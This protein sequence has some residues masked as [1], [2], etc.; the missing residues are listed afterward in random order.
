MAMAPCPRCGKLNRSNARF[1]GGCG[2]TLTPP[3]TSPQPVPTQQVTQPAPQQPAPQPAPSPRYAPPPTAPQPRPTFS[4]TP[5]QTPPST[6][7]AGGMT[8]AVRSTSYA[9]II[10]ALVAAVCIVGGVLVTL[11]MQNGLIPNI[12][13][14]A[15][16]TPTVLATS[17]VAAT[18]TAISAPTST[19]LSGSSVAST[20]TPVAPISTPTDEPTASATATPASIILP[21][22]T[23]TPLAPGALAP[24]TSL[25]VT[26]QTAT[27]S[28]I[29]VSV[30]YADNTPANNVYVRVSTQK[31]DV[32]GNPAV[33]DS[34]D[35]NRT[36][37]AGLVTFNLKPGTYVV[38]ADLA[39][40]AYGNRFNYAV[41]NGALLVLDISLSRIRVGLKDA[42]GKPLG[43]KYVAVYLQKTDISG[44]PARGDQ[45]N[46]NRTDNTGAVIFNVTAGYYDVEIGDI[47]GQPYG[48]PFNHAARAG[49]THSVIVGLGR[50]RVGVKDADGKA[51]SGKYVTVN[52]QKLDVDGKPMIGDRIDSNRTDNTGTIN[53][54]L[55]PGTYATDIGDLWGAKWGD[56]LN[57]QIQSGAT[58]SVVV[59]LGRITVG[60]KSADGKPITGR[61]VTVYFQK[62]DVSG[63]I[64]KG[65]RIDGN[66]TDNAGLLSWDITAGNYILEIEN[67]TPQQNIVVQP[68][69]ITTS[70]GK[71]ATVH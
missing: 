22:A 44:N 28:G 25:R 20:A 6:R 60:L 26:K 41:T 11:L 7:P 62:K 21:D 18:T 68:S 10:L 30:R 61:Y 46:S 34:V 38:E 42:D 16:Q 5:T 33:G 17:A 29:R 45:V 2:L 56:P 57:K 59:S 4:P 66:R 52:F 58:N 69:K 14:G 39:G 27:N 13:L 71:T 3:P 24:L 51:V 48:N 64:T 40:Y 43:G 47:L 19:P 15:T 55:T 8:R 31:Q 54:D 63:N 35:S 50:L 9:L 23:A 32:S 70:D 12:A 36:D 67:I 65:D 1:C 49:E 37:N 53:F